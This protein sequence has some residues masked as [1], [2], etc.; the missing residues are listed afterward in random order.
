MKKNERKN[1]FFE[2]K[3]QKTF[4][5]W[6]RA[7]RNARARVQKF[8]GSFFQKRTS[9]LVLLTLPRPAEA[10]LASTGLGPAYD[11]IAHVA[12]SPEQTLPI[13]ALALFAGRRSPAHARA[14]TFLL[15]AAW[16]CACLAQPDVSPALANILTA[17]ALLGTGLLLACDVPLPVP[18][19]A[20]LSAGLGAG[21]GAA[22]G[23]AS[24]GIAGA[25]AAAACLFVVMAL[26]ASVSLPLRRMQAIIAVRVAG[27]W[28]A[29]LGL[30]MAGWFMHGRQ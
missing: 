12:L 7:S 3:K 4:D 10:H 25:L 5:R 26:M 29:A 6:V 8:F 20:G 2:K 13:A 28:T 23:M 14:A 19:I 22:Y 18:A 11:G 1:F 15:P 24:G 30:L 27:S 16:L 9:L 17:C 21:L